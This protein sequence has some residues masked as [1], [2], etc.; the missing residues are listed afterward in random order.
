MKDFEAKI[1]PK[2]NSYSMYVQFIGKHKLY[3]HFRDFEQ[4]T[5]F[6]LSE[7]YSKSRPCYLQ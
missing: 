1:S 3:Y 4:L 2:I 5:P 6:P 7:T